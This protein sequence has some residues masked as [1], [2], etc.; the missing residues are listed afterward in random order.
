MA[1]ADTQKPQSPEETNMASTGKNS[2]SENHQSRSSSRSKTSKPTRQLDFTQAMT[3]FKHMF[4]TMDSEVIEA[5]LRANDGAVDDTI[6]QLLTMTIDSEDSQEQDTFLET[7][8]LQ[9]YEEHCLQSED[10]DR[11]SEDRDRQSEESPPS[12]SEAMRAMQKQSIW[13]TPV[14]SKMSQPSHNS[15]SKESSDFPDS[16]ELSLS[17]TESK[18]SQMLFSPVMRQ[19]S[20]G[21]RLSDQ[22]INSN[23][24]STA[25]KTVFRNW[26]P[27]M[28]G[29]LPDDFL[30]LDTQSVSSV[31]HTNSSTFASTPI[32]DE[33]PKVHKSKGR[34]VK[35][36]KSLSVTAK[37]SR[38]LKEQSKSGRKS[39]SAEKIHRTLSMA[40]KSLD[41]GLVRE[42]LP[43]QQHASKKRE[44]HSR[45][46]DG[47]RTLSS[48]IQHPMTFPR[49]H[50]LS[51]DI[52]SE[53]MKENERRRKRLSFDVD[54]EMAQYLEDER[55]AILLQ[56]GEFLQELR[57]NEDFMKTLERDR[58]HASAFEPKTPTDPQVAVIRTPMTDSAVEGYGKDKQETLEAFPFSQSVP[59]MEKEKDEDA[60]LRG[61]LKHMGKAS[62]KQFAALARRFFMPKRKKGSRNILKEQTAPSMMNLLDNEEGGDD[63]SDDNFNSFSQ[64]GQRTEIEPVVPSYRTVQRPP[65]RP[66][67]VVTHF[68]NHSV[69]MV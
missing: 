37:D 30:R 6:D 14:F 55:L 27:P 35:L 58:L 57:S 62:R 36:S 52:L 26:N 21:R 34:S 9:S 51:C 59:P 32:Q 68:S 41:P 46:N 60:E 50:E 49:H 4:P 45:S 33:K 47:S 16:D 3:D 42:E 19:S 31:W 53:K 20:S 15:K 39:K 29:T 48:P 38:D 44:K 1:S 54:P 5:V 8:M 28:L 13:T 18:S 2:S 17:D 66:E 63:E 23:N 43:S 10:R 22:S 7:A 69:D 67:G 12:Y 61:Q 64:Y 25:R 65:Y 11:Q 56:N 24:S 40:E